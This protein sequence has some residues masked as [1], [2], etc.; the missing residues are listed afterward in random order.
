MMHGGHFI[1]KGSSSY[2]A[3]EEHN[4]HVQC[5]GCNLYGMKHGIA[6]YRYH[7][8]IIQRYGKKRV[9]QMLADAKKPIKFY[10]ADYR[11]MIRAYN[12]KINKLKSKM[13]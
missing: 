9:Q 11:E 8:Y 2:H 5:P 4:V 1:P 7:E 13:L 10:A 12:A 3:F 6:P